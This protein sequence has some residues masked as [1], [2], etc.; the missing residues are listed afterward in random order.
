[1]WFLPG[2]HISTIFFRQFGFNP[3]VGKLLKQ[4]K[5]LLQPIKVN[6][7]EVVLFHRNL[8]HGSSVNYLPKNRI[9]I[10]SVIVSKGAQLY[11]FHREEAFVK[12]KIL[13]YK[14]DMQH[15]LRE[16]PKDD[17]YNQVYDYEMF[18]DLGMEGITKKIRKELP[19]Y[20]AYSSKAY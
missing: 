18:K 10:E 11:N 9:A 16:S 17:F 6:A 1:M 20:L 5:P 2:S 8:I 3:Y 19:K 13:G 15:F 7:G 4:I 14:V 12:N